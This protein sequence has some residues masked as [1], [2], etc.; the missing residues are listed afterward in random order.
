MA[1]KRN[2]QRA[3]IQEPRRKRGFSHW[4]SLM[5]TEFDDTRD[6]GFFVR[7]SKTL[8]NS[9]GF[10]TRWSEL[11]L[12]ALRAQGVFDIMEDGTTAPAHDKLW[13]DKNTDPAVLK[14][15]DSVS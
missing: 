1:A 14:E 8:T 6:Y 10:A 12:A 3:D 2:Q 9:N 4:E 5:A 11:A 15:W 13:L 7:D